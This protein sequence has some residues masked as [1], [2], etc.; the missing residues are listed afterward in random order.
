MSMK[1]L[2]GKSIT[3]SVDFM[4]DSVEIKKL[5]VAE[6]MEIQNTAK[7]SAKSETETAQM[8]LLR[9]VIRI[10]VKDAEELTDADFDTFP[11]DELSKLSEAIMEF[12][13]L[14]EKNEGN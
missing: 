14:G 12:S 1:K 13:G 7:K 2:V 11:L 3:K 9:K 4:G 8:A 6:V 10:A 5:S